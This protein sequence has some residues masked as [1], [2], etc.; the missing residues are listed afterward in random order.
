MVLDLFCRLHTKHESGIQT[1]NLE[2]S[3][4]GIQSETLYLDA[5]ESETFRSVNALRI[6]RNTLNVMNPETFMNLE[7]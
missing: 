7:T 2:T 3:E 4:S 6:F 5:Y 1:V